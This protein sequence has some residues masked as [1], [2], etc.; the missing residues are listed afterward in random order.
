MGDRL[1]RYKYDELNRIES[2]E[3]LGLTLKFKYNNA[4]TIYEIDEINDGVH[5]TYEFSNIQHDESGDFTEQVSIVGGI[6]IEKMKS[7]TMTSTKIQ[8]GEK[9]LEIIQRHDNPPTLTQT[10]IS[11]EK[12]DTI[13][14]FLFNEQNL[15][16]SLSIVDISGEFV[17]LLDYTFDNKGNWIK[18]AIKEKNNKQRKI[19]VT[20]RKISYY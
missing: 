12:D 17:V 5:K 14:T 9:I 10:M 1:Y 18:R 13:M 4:G 6:R 7:K 3:K 8:K 11:L 19:F 20:E 15:V 2:I 16:S